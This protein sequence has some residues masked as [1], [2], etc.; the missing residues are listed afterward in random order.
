MFIVG[1]L[2]ERHRPMA[3]ASL[4]LLAMP[5]NAYGQQSDI[6][7][8][9]YSVACQNMHIAQRTY[10]TIQKQ[11]AQRQYEG[12][13]QRNHHQ[14]GVSQRTGPTAGMSQDGGC[15]WIGYQWSTQ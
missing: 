12:Y 7:Q 1:G 14:N 8:P 4:L 15:G 2:S 10:E 5:F 6:C 11:N 9:S 13:L 3:V